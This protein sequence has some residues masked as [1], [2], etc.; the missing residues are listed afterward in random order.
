M[1]SSVR[2][3]ASR[4]SISSPRAMRLNQSIEPLER[5]L[6]LSSAIRQTEGIPTPDCFGGS[7]R[8]FGLDAALDGEGN[9][10]VAGYTS[11]ADFPIAGGFQTAY[12]GGESDAFLARFSPD[13]GTMLW[14]TF[15]GGSGADEITRIAFGSDNSVYVLGNTTSAD[16]PGG[17]VFDGASQDVFAARIAPDGSAILWSAGVATPVSDQAGGIALDSAGNVFICGG[18]DSAELTHTAGFDGGPSGGADAFIAA[19]SAATGTI[20]WTGL[21]GGQGTDIAW[22]VAVDN[23]GNAVVVGSTASADFPVAN[24]F[25]IRPNGY[26][27]AFVASIRPDGSA[28]A[29]SG[30][31]GGSRSDEAREVETDADG[32]IFIAGTTRSSNLPAQAGGSYAGDADIFTAKIAA[33]GGSIEWTRLTGGSSAEATGDMAIDNSGNIFIAG[34]TTS[35]DFSGA[36]E[37]SEGSGIAAFLTKFTADGTLIPISGIIDGDRDDY[38]TGI[39]VNGNAEIVISGW[40][41]STDPG[42]TVIAGPG[43]QQDVLLG[44]MQDVAPIAFAAETETP[45][46]EPVTFSLGGYDPNGDALTYE[47][48]SGPANGS[49][50]GIAPN[51]TYSP[52]AGFNGTEIITYSVTDGTN[53]SAPASASITVT[54]VNS[55]PVADDLTITLQEDGNALI[56]LSA[57]DAETPYQALSFSLSNPENGGLVEISHGRYVYTPSADWNGIEELTL[58]VSDS[59]DPATG[60]PLGGIALTDTSVVTLN[61]F[62]VNDRPAGIPARADTVVNTPIVLALEGSDADGDVMTF[63]IV[64]APARGKLSPAPGAADDARWTYTP[65]AFFNGTDTISFTVSDGALVSYA[66]TFTV[67][68]RSAANNL[69]TSSPARV[70]ASENTEIII[71]LAGADP[72]GSLLTYGIVAS[73]SHGTLSPLPGKDNDNQ[74]TYTPDADWNSGPSG[75]GEILD[76]FTYYANDGLANSAPAR[77][78]IYVAPINEPPV[79]VAPIGLTTQEDTQIEFTLSGTDLETSSGE[80][81]LNVPLRSSHGT[82]TPVG[83]N[84]GVFSYLPD[85]DFSGTDSFT[86]TVTDTGEPI[87]PTIGDQTSGPVAVEIEVTPSNNA[88]RA[89]PRATGTDVNTGD[90]TGVEIMLFALDREGSPVTYAIGAHPEH[91]TIILISP[92]D[93][94]YVTYVPDFG[95]TGTDTFTYFASDGDL[96]GEAATVTVFVA[97]GAIPPTASSPQ[98]LIVTQEDKPI[99]VILPG[100]DPDGGALSYFIDQPPAHGALSGNAGSAVWTY[101]PAAGWSGE[102]SFLFHVKDGK[103]DSNIAPVEIRVTPVDDPPVAQNGSATVTWGMTY[104]IPIILSATDP[105]SGLLTFEIL[106]DHMPASG[107]LVPM[108]GLSDTGNCW[109]YTYTPAPDADAPATDSFQFT[110]SD[111]TTTS[112]PANFTINIVEPSVSFTS[113]AVD[114]A[115]D[116]PTIIPPGHTLPIYW[117]N[118]ALPS[119][120][121]V[122]MF[123]DT[124][125]D[126]ENGG[127]EPL[128]GGDLS[129]SLGN[130]NWRIPVEFAGDNFR[131]AARLPDGR[132][133][134]APGEVRVRHIEHP[135]VNAPSGTNVWLIDLDGDPENDLPDHYIPASFVTKPE[136]TLGPVVLY[137]L[138]GEVG[139]IVTSSAPFNGIRAFGQYPIAFA[140]VQAPK[141]S[142]IY[143]Q[144]GFSGYDLNGLRI[145]E[146]DVAGIPRVTYM[147]GDDIDD[148]TAMDDPTALSVNG[149]LNRF[150]DTTGIW[151]DMLISGK[152]GDVLLTQ[153]PRLAHDLRIT[154]SVD[155]MVLPSIQEGATVSVGSA[156]VVVSSVV[157]GELSISGNAAVLVADSVAAT[158]VISAGSSDK[159]FVKDSVFGMVNVAG[160]IGVFFAASILPGGAISAAETDVFIVRNEVHGA[161][162]FTAPGGNVSLMSLGSVQGGTITSSGTLNKFVSGAF[163]GELQATRLNSVFIL[164]ETQGRIWSRGRVE[165]FYSISANGLDASFLEGANLISVPGVVTNSKIV[166]GYDLALGRPDSGGA[167]NYVYVGGL[168]DS[169]V[170]AGTNPVDGLW[171]DGNDEAGVGS[172]SRVF[173]LG[174]ITNS[175]VQASS[176]TFI[177]YSA[178]PRQFVTVP[179]D[180]GTV[181]VLGD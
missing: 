151:G 49:L 78:D 174:R 4:L 16:F 179:P 57:T 146:N 62:P 28:M 124:D 52:D 133:V 164:G 67:N 2:Y 43:G 20:S 56:V 107:T 68:V 147:F 37:P 12:A 42:A 100:S 106:A 17:A 150:I 165:T 113:V 134:Y 85:L 93:N 26:E 94:A 48:I 77:I 58:T 33:G 47:I 112:A 173:C 87:D 66:A 122:R 82:L 140:Q 135:V 141:T 21:L 108:Q 1:R 5:R 178:E 13:G 110:V 51:L 159:L 88:P 162:S 32:N 76:S 104:E 97:E 155:R 101:T 167:L 145:V 154:A 84:P 161:V 148:D 45:E 40:S 121:R 111:G 11:S 158:G 38:F 105:D 70:S 18:A 103:H 46:N 116:G 132:Y 176:G 59:G 92:A 181:R 22:D 143:S 118:I 175:T 99:A 8:D 123:L 139:V 63:A 39:G 31:F 136:D 65:D 24:A 44:I 7:L 153:D 55:P 25:D 75:E 120:A 157:E 142:L 19:I 138:Y 15:L 172:F 53:I 72:D 169:V 171:G 156:K 170:S 54:P 115:L 83:D 131:I 89:I 114:K 9:I 29:W 126:H 91:G 130:F 95:F 64:T 30:L 125:D 152:A 127:L 180:L 71:T 81:V 61:V 41:A 160:D 35:P 166:S 168:V 27:D 177:F 163:S 80:L 117:S 144:A 34:W 60:Q 96:A 109:L 3:S 149:D 137:G 79:A 98:S 119:D 86:F 36:P 90:H 128:P 10:Y 14:S 129:V 102:D 23:T 50:S 69:P 6:L 74:W 73:P